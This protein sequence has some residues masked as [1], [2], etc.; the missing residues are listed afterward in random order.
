MFL[1][2][3]D[4]FH[5]IVSVSFFPFFPFLFQIV[6]RAG[7][8]S[9]FSSTCSLRFVAWPVR[10]GVSLVCISVLKFVTQDHEESSSLNEASARTPVVLDVDWWKHHFNVTN[11]HRVRCEST[12]QDG[13]ELSSR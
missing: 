12:R 5:I 2:F 1:F 6:W 7:L 10:L 13:A 9:F 8:H 3:S 4:L 11:T